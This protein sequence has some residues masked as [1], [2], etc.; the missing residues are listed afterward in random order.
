[1]TWSHAWGAGQ[2]PALGSGL[3]RFLP[4]RPGTH[5]SASHA[6]GS[7]DVSGA[8]PDL[9]KTGP[10]DERELGPLRVLTLHDYLVIVG[11]SN[12]FSMMLSGLH[13]LK[14]IFRVQK[15]VHFRFQCVPFW[16]VLAWPCL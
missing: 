11:G 4:M 9:R 5:F 13:L 12:I 14:C 3:G 8:R 2:T 16:P 15:E 6:A 10:S 1:M 7:G